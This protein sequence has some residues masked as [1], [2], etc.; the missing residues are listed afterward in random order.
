VGPFISRQ[1]I[2]RLVTSNPSPEY[3]SRVA[4]VFN[5]NGSGVRGDLKAVVQAILLDTEARRGDDPAQAQASDG[6]L[7][8][9]VLFT[10]NLLRAMN[11]VS[12]GVG[13]ADR[14]SDMKQPP[15]FSPTVF[16]FYHPDH[17]IEGT[18]LLGPEFEIFNT[19]TAISRINFVNTLVY[20]Q[21]SSTTA[22]DLPG[23]VPL[24]A[25]PDQ[26][27]NAVAAVM[28]HG[29]VSDDMRATL[30]TTLSGISDNTRRTKA[31]FYLM[32][33]S[34]QFQVEH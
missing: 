16:N 11:G 25:A 19:S 9:P 30:V 8:E 1:L 23:Y 34:S 21:L 26:L 22:V 28:L 6:H 13:L 33:S 2:Q 12:D 32:G 5:D 15:F 3:V 20:N 7:K 31:A 24:A 14:A 17:V 4:G 29:Q 10:T 27:V 18:T